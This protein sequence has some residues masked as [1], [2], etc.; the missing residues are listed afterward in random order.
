[1]KYILSILAVVFSFNAFAEEEKDYTVMTISAK[2]VEKVIPDIYQASLNLKFENKDKKQ[3]Q[4]KL[5]NEVIDAIKALKKAELK[6]E[7]SDFSVRPSN[8]Y[9]YQAM[10]DVYLT[11]KNVSRLKDYKKDAKVEKIGNYYRTKYTVKA[12]ADNYNDAKIALDRLVEDIRQDSQLLSIGFS[13]KI[14]PPKNI[15]K[16]LF[17]AQ[18]TITVKTSD[19]EKMKQLSIDFS[20]KIENA[21]SYVSEKLKEQQREKLFK[22]AYDKAIK[23]ANFVVK[24]MGMSKFDIARVNYSTN[25]I[26][27]YRNYS[28]KA[29]AMNT[30]SESVD[31]GVNLD[32][33]EKKVNLNLTI[34]LKI[35]K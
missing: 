11:V 32:D 2:A 23:E 33:S 30:M 21:T 5:N 31:S 18:Q 15:K 6:Y 22:Q 26:T 4:K 8:D 35:Y 24:T 34:N 12:D 10:A 16:D 9:T 29:V 20:G 28:Y 3:A 19:N 1:M 13:K 25:D 14:F 27:P 7:I 17:V